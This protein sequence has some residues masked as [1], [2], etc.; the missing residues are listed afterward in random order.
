MYTVIVELTSSK[1]LSKGDLQKLFDH[2]PLHVTKVTASLHDRV[3]VIYKASKLTQ[4]T[5][6]PLFKQPV[7]IDKPE[8]PPPDLDADLKLFED[9]DH[10]PKDP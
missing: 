1:D 10:A 3:E 8:L 9:D 2:V 4:T 5:P 6:E 7:V